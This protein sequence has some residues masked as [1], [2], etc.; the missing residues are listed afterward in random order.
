M[1]RD[2]V[3]TIQIQQAS[4]TLH[5]NDYWLLTN[6]VDGSDLPISIMLQSKRLAVA[7]W[8]AMDAARLLQRRFPGRKNVVGIGV[9]M[10]VERMGWTG[11]GI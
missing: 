3:S 1:E 8:L 7:G 9:W 2:C 11:L 4:G 6:G 10:M 5:V